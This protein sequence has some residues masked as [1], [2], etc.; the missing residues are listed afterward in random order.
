MK[1]IDSQTRTVRELFANIKYNLDYYQREYVWQTEHVT[2]LIG[3]L[4]DAFSNNYKPEHERKEVGSYA[5]YFLGAI[6]ICE[7]DDK[8]FIIDGQ[9]RLT[10][11]TLL[12]IYLDRWLEEENEMSPL[13]PLI[14]SESYGKKSFNLDIPERASVMDFLRYRDNSSDNFFSIKGPA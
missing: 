3:D 11:L 4:T 1:K 5:H 2:E 9:Q 13:P 10:T 12:L 7:K 8:R 6:V 14:F